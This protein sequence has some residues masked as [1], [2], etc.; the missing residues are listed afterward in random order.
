VRITIVTCPTHGCLRPVVVALAALSMI[1]VAPRLHAEGPR[2]HAGS[3]GLPAQVAAV[4]DEIRAKDSGQ[5]AVS[6]EDGRFLRLMVASSRS[7]RA[8][9]IGGASGYSAIW[10]GLGLRDTGGRLTT[11]EYDE[12]RARELAANVERA[13]LADIVTVVSG[14]AFVRVP[15]VSGTF[16]FV[17][18]D[19]WKRDYRRFFEL[20]FPRLEPGGLLLAHNV[21]NKRSELED[22]LAAIDR[23]PGLWNTIV[24]PSGEGISLSYRRRR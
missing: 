5:L 16:D 8:L 19:A 17:F 3:D 14:D 6:H 12:T 2:P 1:V 15:E 22:F 13:G 21:V 9:E 24:S 4:L 10:I 7:R 18:V 20:V 23:T 11:I